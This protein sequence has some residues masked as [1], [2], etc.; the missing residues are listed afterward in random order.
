MYLLLTKN[1]IYEGSEKL[2]FKIQNLDINSCLRVIHVLYVWVTFFYWSCQSGSNYT[3]F[4][5]SN[6]ISFKNYQRIC[7]HRKFIDGIAG[8]D[9]KGFFMF[10]GKIHQ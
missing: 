8:V 2:N 3:S 5:L 6:D 7:D 10:I 1:K 9:I 4:S